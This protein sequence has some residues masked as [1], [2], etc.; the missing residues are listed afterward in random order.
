MIGAAIGGVENLSDILWDFQP[1][2]VL[3]KY[4]EKVFGAADRLRSTTAELI[5]V[6]RL[7]AA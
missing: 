3:D 6:K 4:A 1:N 7:S 5:R 2:G